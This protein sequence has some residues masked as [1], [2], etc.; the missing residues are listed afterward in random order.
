MKREGKG[1]GRSGAWSG[2]VA[3]QFPANESKHLFEAGA[4]KALGWSPSPPFLT[5]ERAD[6]P[7]DA[8][9]RLFARPCFAAAG[10][11]LVGK[12]L[13]SSFLPSAD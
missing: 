12:H 4:R 13:L 11:K 2:H 7:S 3:V 6:F 9:P 10:Q 8:L 5:M 1:Q